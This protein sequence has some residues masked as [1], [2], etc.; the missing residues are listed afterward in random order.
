LL[1]SLSLSQGYHE[2]KLAK[3]IPAIKALRKA[4]QN[5]NRNAI[6]KKN[7]DL[8]HR[9]TARTLDN[10]ES[11]KFFFNINHFQM[12]IRKP[13]NNHLI[14]L[15]E[16]KAVFAVMF[17]TGMRAHSIENLFINSVHLKKVKPKM[18]ATPVI[19]VGITIPLSKMN[20][21]TNTSFLL[22]YKEPERCPIFALGCHFIVLCLTKSVA[23]GIWSIIDCLMGELDKVEAFQSTANRN[24]V[25]VECAY[26]A[27]RLFSN[28]Y[29]SNRGF[30]E[31]TI[32]QY[33]DQFLQAADIRKAAKMHLARDTVA[34]DIFEMYADKRDHIHVRSFLHQNHDTMSHVYAQGAVMLETF[35]LG[36]WKS[37]EDFLLL[38]CAEAAQLPKLYGEFNDQLQS[39]PEEMLDG[40][41]DLIFP[42]IKALI[43]RAAAAARH[44]KP[45]TSLYSVLTT[46]NHCIRR[47]LQ[48]LTTLG[49]PTCAWNIPA[50]A[51]LNTIQFFDRPEWVAFNAKMCEVVQHNANVYEGCMHG[52][53][54][55][56]KE[57]YPEFEQRARTINEQRKASSEG[58]L[59]SYAAGVR[60]LARIEAGLCCAPADKPLPVFKLPQIIGAVEA[61]TFYRDWCAKDPSNPDLPSM[62]EYATGHPRIKWQEDFGMTGAMAACFKVWLPCCL[63]PCCL[64]PCCLLFV[65]AAL[66]PAVC[67]V[68]SLLPHPAS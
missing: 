67:V 38:D 28:P 1:L 46:M 7:K 14:V 4:Q 49:G 19:A 64:L 18:C 17:A 23:P 20:N 11:D 3:D 59:A 45:E 6:K 54:K 33:L 61:S 41:V 9:A 63:L 21:D 51:F 53:A 13:L 39:V 44:L 32:R 22:D 34:H 8:Q 40:L 60:S 24:T 37:N 68:A 50:V 48:R 57:N 25:C 58:M 36:G 16:A 42:N 2:V 56:R 55:S 62:G 31:F 10:D 5:A 26:W 47:A 29:I 65:P 52:E 66:L 30:N 35:L 12:V 43:E 15:S 27:Y